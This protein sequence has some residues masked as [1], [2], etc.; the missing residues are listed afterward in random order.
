M[1]MNDL[2]ERNREVVEFLPG[3]N[4]TFFTEQMNEIIKLLIQYAMIW[5]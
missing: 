4:F 5:G 1:R 3:E 2:F